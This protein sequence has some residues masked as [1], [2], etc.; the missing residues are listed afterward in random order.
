MKPVQSI[1]RPRASR[2]EHHLII[3][4]ARLNMGTLAELFR[5]LMTGGRWW[6]VPMVAVL[7]LAALLLA[8]VAAVEYVA[9]FVYT[10]F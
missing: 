5:A 9:P 4:R 1:A 8:A 6:M 10:I 7:G 2:G 3:T